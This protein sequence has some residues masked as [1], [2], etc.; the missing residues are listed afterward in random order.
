[1]PERLGLMAENTL[2]YKDY[3]I[4][5][6]TALVGSP[7]GTGAR[8]IRNAQLERY[9][10]CQEQKICT[11]AEIKIKHYTRSIKDLESTSFVT[12]QASWDIAYLI[13]SARRALPICSNTAV[14]VASSPRKLWNDSVLNAL[15]K[16]RR[17]L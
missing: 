15:V 7:L 4:P 10:R 17:A 6:V 3:T 9:G 16:G 14:T 2:R 11:K 1:M 12:L 5:Q 8:K 13:R